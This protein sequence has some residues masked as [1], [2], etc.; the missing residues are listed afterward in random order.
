MFVM[1]CACNRIIMKSGTATMPSLILIDDEG[2]NM[3]NYLTWFIFIENGMSFY[4]SNIQLSIS[5]ETL[6]VL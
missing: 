2:E 4:L 1:E 6:K 5:F 3:Y